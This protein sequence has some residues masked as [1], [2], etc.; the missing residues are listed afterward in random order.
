MFA[1]IRVYVG[2]SPSTRTHPPAQLLAM[3]RPVAAQEFDNR[4]NE[5][6]EAQAVQAA[7][8]RADIEAKHKAAGEWNPEVAFAQ[9]R[10]SCVKLHR[11]NTTATTLPP[12]SS[13][14]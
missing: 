13:S 1:T 11:Q 2:L 5:L 10:L 6:A 14:P 12:P 4:D 7:Q 9:C 3:D 8:Q